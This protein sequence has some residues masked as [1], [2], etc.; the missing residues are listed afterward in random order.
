M[1]GRGRAYGDP[2]WLRRAWCVAPHDIGLQ[3]IG[4][5][6]AEATVHAHLGSGGAAAPPPLAFALLQTL[7]GWCSHNHWGNDAIS[8]TNID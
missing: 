4:I 2:W 5:N 8:R 1:R 3:P 7:C 6:L